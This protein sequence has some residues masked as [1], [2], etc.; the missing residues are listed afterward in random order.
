MTIKRLFLLLLATV[1]LATS[2]LLAFPCPNGSAIIQ[3]AAGNSFQASKLETATMTYTAGSNGLN[4]GDKIALRVPDG[5]GYPYVPVTAGPENFPG[6][7]ASTAPGVAAGLTTN[8]SSQMIIVTVTSGTVSAGD[9][10]KIYYWFNA[11]PT[12]SASSGTFRVSEYGTGCSPAEFREIFNQGYSLTTGPGS[13]LR[14]SKNDYLAVVNQ[15][16]ATPIHVTDACGTV[17][18]ATSSLSFQIDL[19]HDDYS[20]DSSLLALSTSSSMTPKGSSISTTVIN[21]TTLYY[22]LTAIDE[23]KKRLKMTYIPHGLTYFDFRYAEITN[24]SAG[25]SNPSV[26]TGVFNTTQNSATFTPDQNNVDDFAYIN[27]NLPADANW[28]VKIS[29]HSNFS[30]ITRTLTGYG[31]NNRISWDGMSDGS[32]EAQP[33]IAAPGTYYVKIELNGLIPD[34]S[35]TIVLNSA[36]IKGKILTGSTPVANVNVDVF[37]Q[38]NRFVRTKSDGTFSIYGLRAGSYSYRMGKEGFENINQST[39]ITA[40][41]ILDLGNIQM[42]QA[43][44]ARV[45]VH[46]TTDAV[47]NAE[48]W[49]SVN[50]N[51]L[52]WRYNSYGSIHFGVNKTTSDA[53]DLWNANPTTY[54]ALSMIPG[55]TYNVRFEIPGLGAGPI[56]IGPLAPGQII[57]VSTNS[58]RRANIHGL[59]CVPSTTTI[60][61]NPW[62]SV[63]A[64]IDANHDGNFDS[65]DSSK[66]YY[67]GGS[68]QT[69]V[70]CS[71][72]SINGVAPGTYSVAARVPQFAPHV[73]TNVVVLG[74]QD[75]FVDLSTVTTGGMVTGTITINGDLSSHPNVSGNMLPLSVSVWSPSTFAGA[76]GEAMIPVVSSITVTTGTYVLSGLSNGTYNFWTNLSGFELTPPGQRSVTVA[77]GSG[78]LDL[79]FNQYGGTLQVNA[80]VPGNNF[81]NTLI[82]L[83]PYDFQFQKVL[84]TLSA[85]THTFNKL[86][87]G[88]YTL[89]VRY[90]PTGNTFERN[91]QI[92]NGQT[93]EINVDLTGTTFTIAGTVREQINEGTFDTLDHIINLST[94]TSLTNSTA[95]ISQNYPANRI[96]ARRLLV[97]DDA[98]NNGGAANN[99]YSFDPW[100]TFYG[101]Y[102]TAGIYS[103]PNLTPGIY[104]LSNNGE[105]NNNIGDGKEIA[106]TATVV[107]LTTSSLNNQ[108]FTLTNGFIIEG[109]LVVDSGVT[110]TGRQLKVV[111]KNGRGNTLASSDVFLNGISAIF[112]LSHI[113]PG[114]YVL[115]VEDNTYPVKKYAA[116]D[117]TVEVVSTD[118][119]NQEIKLLTAAKIQ[120]QLRIKTSGELITNQNFQQFLPDQFYIEARSNPWFQG[121]WGRVEGNLIAGDNTF[122]LSVSPGTYDI[123]FQSRDQLTPSEIAE[124]KKS[125][126]PITLSG[127][128]VTAG[129]TTNVG[130]IDLREGVPVSGTVT[131]TDGN[132]LPNIRM[133]ADSGMHQS[134]SDPE[135]FTDKLGKYTLLGLDPEGL[136]F[137]DIVAAPRPESRDDRFSNTTSTTSYGESRKTHF[138]TK[139]SPMPTVNF[140]LEL[141]LGSV[142]GIAAIPTG[143][144]QALQLP[145][146]EGQGVNLPGALVIMNKQGDLPSKNP[147]GDIEEK[148]NPDGTFTIKGLTPGSYDMWVL[149]L[150]Y[151]SAIKRDIVV[152][153]ADVNIGT[154]T[155]VDGFK[156]S[157]T[158][159]KSDG[160]PLSNNEVETMI[161]VRDGFEEIIIGRTNEDAAG[162]IIEYSM[163]GFRSGKTYSVILFGRND[164][165][166]IP[167]PSTVTL[168]A[169]SVQD[170]V[171]GNVTPVILTQATKVSASTITIQFDLSKP[172]RN[173]DTDT[174]NAGTGDGTPDDSQFSKIIRLKTGTGTLS[175][176]EDTWISQD[177]KG[178]IVSYHPSADE[179]TFVL[180]ASCTFISVNG[181]TGENDIVVKDFTYYVGIGRQRVVQIA[182][183]AGGEAEL[184]E[185]QSSFESQSG[186]FG[187]DSALVVAVGFRA[188]DLQEDLAGQVAI[189]SLVMSKAA[190]LGLKA[191]PTGMAAAIQHLKALAIDP[192]SSF[193][194]IVLPQGVSHFFPEGKSAKLCLQYDSEVTDPHALNIYYFNE[195]TNQ[196]L[197]EN[198]NKVVDTDNEKICVDL[199]HASIFTVLASSQTILSGSGYTGEL[200]VVNFPNPF[201]LKQKT[202][203]LQDSGGNSASQTIDGTMIK[204][205][206]PTT[207]SGA[208]EIEIFNVAGEKVRTLH[209]TASGGAN[210]Y[211]EWDGKNDGGNKVASGVYIGRFTI[212]GSNEKFFK[213][214]VVK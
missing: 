211:I 174:D 104:L 148:T 146:D 93:T 167:Q 97:R 95:S 74:S 204:M 67:A 48:L 168:T 165:V 76:W 47:N 110:E 202:V 33:E 34:T 208:I 87:T 83:T 99:A 53:G 16:L 11:C 91:V 124:G 143:G 5:W 82:E 66:R 197:L 64:G 191:Y 70:R 153:N 116:K 201:N 14:F 103:I 158:L 113:P 184:D 172:L 42:N 1:G 213:M 160:S 88:F 84:S 40:G 101:T 203:T 51:T 37:G 63:E 102:D 164:D 108:D 181:S 54:T 139:Q 196:Y 127:I 107:S 131:D 162:N 140:Q 175:H 96:I 144:T 72:F 179:T 94:P 39:S 20:A 129:Q 18:P 188:A 9:T 185:D 75:K 125:F 35:L 207:M 59:V 161:C 195:A 114:T 118:I 10:I 92:V 78:Q 65:F 31:R 189:G 62:Y 4:V 117:I 55:Q 155:M 109:R 111:L 152:G 192:F 130:V 182:N 128:R 22:Q 190:Q 81:A 180:T 71:S 17:S 56:T 24:V 32:A 154:M 68:F 159:T 98:N 73:S 132:P 205:S 176:D 90:L 187:D 57:D 7:A 151:G 50:A 214:A 194:D 133:I 45:V 27:F 6:F 157:G 136:R 79:T 163:S 137:Y 145:F 183:A 46:R 138:D 85:A 200:R 149:A 186:T 36:G 178:L 8:T 134:D 38:P 29:S 171:V 60:V 2:R 105:M 150:N 212:G 86:G 126:A 209:N 156:M 106:E 119:S 193:Y 206:I 41:Q 80:T 115:T 199:S 58:V 177:R 100:V 13:Q 169:D 49:G 26:D 142:S 210:F 120:G 19:L 166:I 23:I 44:V 3:P 30:T 89:R 52:D 25:I 15:V 121:G 173:S 135:T 12:T 77:N 170:F 141:A 43:A 69:D 198:T 123:V 28:L 112:S 147:L 61:N 21:S 122:N